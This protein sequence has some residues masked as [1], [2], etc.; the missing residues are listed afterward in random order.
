MEAFVPSAFT[1]GRE[2][3]SRAG[4]CRQK[5]SNST[6]AVLA[7][8][9][10]ATRPESAVAAPASSPTSRAHSIVKLGTS[11]ELQRMLTD[12]EGVVVL[13]C[14]TTNCRSCK[15]VAPRFRKVA[16]AYSHIA[17]FA[18]MDYKVNQEYCEALGVTHLPFFAFW[19]NGTYLGGEAISWQRMS[20]L[21]DRIADVVEPHN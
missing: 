16:A 1:P 21:T 8:P 20:K 10:S 5:R 3:I 18:E 14:Y 6:K 19:R 2:K 17:S 12:T 15:G 7:T 9:A 13:K 4:P 11:A